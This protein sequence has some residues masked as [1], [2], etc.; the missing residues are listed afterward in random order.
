MSPTGEAVAPC[1]CMRETK[2]AMPLHQQGTGRSYS[3][4]VKDVPSASLLVTV[5]R[6]LTSL[7]PQ[8]P[9]PQISTPI[10]SSYHYHELSLKRITN[11]H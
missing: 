10:P 5:P 8:H 4:K 3:E 9:A 1:V 2:Q 7:A 6:I 11:L